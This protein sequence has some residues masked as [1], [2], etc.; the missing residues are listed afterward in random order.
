MQPVMGNIFDHGY[1][2][3][4]KKHILVPFQYTFFSHEGKIGV[5]IIQF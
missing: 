4:P 1:P 2:S 5:N 3:L